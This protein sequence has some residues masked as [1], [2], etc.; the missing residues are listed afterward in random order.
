[1]KP[2]IKSTAGILALVSLLAGCAAGS[3]YQRPDTAM[4][5]K[6]DAIPAAQDNK[7]NAQ[8]VS[9]E[10]WKQFGSAELNQ[11]MDQGPCFARP[12]IEQANAVGRTI[13]QRR[14]GPQQSGCSAHHRLVA[15]RHYR[16]L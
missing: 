7:G 6:W 1:M 16:G 13:G 14:Q 12:C 9:A 3:P 4:P 11:L 10:W 5:E 8:A 15:G 2:L